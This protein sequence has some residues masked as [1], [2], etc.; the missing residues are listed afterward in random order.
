MRKEFTKGDLQ[1]GYI[2]V[3][4]KRGNVILISDTFKKSK[5]LLSDNI[6]AALNLCNDDLKHWSK[7]WQELNIEKVYKII[8]CKSSSLGEIIDELPEDKVELIWERKKEIDW[9][10]VPRFTR[11][12]VRDVDSQSWKNAYFIRYDN[13]AEF[14]FS[15]TTTYFGDFTFT[16]EISTNWKQIRIYD[17]SEIKEE[18]YK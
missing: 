10:K 17:E 8:S 11:V 4:K 2:V 1:T 9:S 18:W 5:D 6:F 13:E 16:D 3:T 14:G 15:Y 12:Q 7:H